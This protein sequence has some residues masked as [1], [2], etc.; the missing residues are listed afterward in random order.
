M[1]LAC[2]MPMVVAVQVDSI[3]MLKI[4]LTSSAA[5]VLLDVSY[6]YDMMCDCPLPVAHIREQSLHR[7]DAKKM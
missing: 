3:S 1:Q 7:I 4:S 6:G 5:P 2:E